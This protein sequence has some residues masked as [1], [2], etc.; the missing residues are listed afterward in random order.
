MMIGNIIYCNDFSNLYVGGGDLPCRH[1][2]AA[3]YFVSQ[4]Q[5]TGVSHATS[6]L[7]GFGLIYPRRYNAGFGGFLLEHRGNLCCAPSE[8]R[9]V[10]GVKASTVELVAG[11]LR[12]ACHHISN[13]LLTFIPQRYSC[14]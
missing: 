9:D 6:S 13:R 14:H 4:A 5:H 1:G 10:D 3:F 2:E 8:C 11:H 7:V 12:K